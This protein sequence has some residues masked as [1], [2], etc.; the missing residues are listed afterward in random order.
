MLSKPKKQAEKVFKVGGPI[1]NPTNF[2]Y[3]EMTKT[4]SFL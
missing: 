2:L 3:M 4:E 1:K